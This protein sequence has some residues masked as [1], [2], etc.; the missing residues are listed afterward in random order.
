MGGT[1]KEAVY[2]LSFQKSCKNGNVCVGES[3]SY[4]KQEIR[5][6]LSST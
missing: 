4:V 3:L 1:K 2:Q 6:L 5:I